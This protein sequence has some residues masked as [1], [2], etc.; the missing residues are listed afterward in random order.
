MGDFKFL[1]WSNKHSAWW[2]PNAMGYTTNKDE[3][4]RYDEL[5]AV[6]HVQQSA[7]HGDISQVTCMI[8]DPVA[9]RKNI[10]DNSRVRLF[11]VAFDATKPN[12]GDYLEDLTDAWL[13]DI[14][15]WMDEHKDDKIIHEALQEDRA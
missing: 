6:Q 1:L 4:G 10:L 15:A 5:E 2:K 12:P 11:W 9:S 8:I 7:F 14:F 13:R 3:A